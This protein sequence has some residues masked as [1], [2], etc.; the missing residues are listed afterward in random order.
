MRQSA[1]ANV[2]TAGFDTV[3]IALSPRGGTVGMEPGLA[4][5][6]TALTLQERQGGETPFPFRLANISRAT[7][8]SHARGV[9]DS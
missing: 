4:W 3:V 1:V 7:L 2:A 9:T 5:T 6:G 8:A